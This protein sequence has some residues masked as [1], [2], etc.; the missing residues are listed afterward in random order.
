MPTE[1]N[2]GKAVAERIAVALRPRDGWEA[3]DLGF[4]MVRAWWRPLFT[5]WLAI[6]LPL[7]LA[8]QA[9]LVESPWLAL[10][11]I[12]WLKPLYDRVALFVLSEALFGEAPNLRA[13]VRALPELLRTRLLASLTWLRLSPLRSLQLP[14]VQLERLRGPARSERTR[15][16]I[17]RDSRLAVGLHVVCLHFELVLLIGLLQSLELFAPQAPGVGDLASLLG[18][19]AP[20]GASWTVAA[21]LVALSI[22]EPL[23]V[24]GGFGLYINRRVYLE[25]WD[26]DLMFRR[27]A[28]RRPRNGTAAAAG[29]LALLLVLPSLPAH[30]DEAAP[31]EKAAPFGVECGTAAN[32]AAACI[33]RILDSEEF[34]TTREQT[35]W[36]PRGWSSEPREASEPSV[37]WLGLAEAIARLVRLLA[38]LALL[39]SVTALVYW[40]SRQS[41]AVGYGPATDDPLDP[42]R[43]ED[44]RAADAL[45]ADPVAAARERWRSGD[46]VG[47]LGLLYRAALEHLAGAAGLA[48][49]LGATEEECQRAAEQRAEPA[50]ASDFSSLVRAWQYCAYARS[51]PDEAAFLELC[52]RWQPRLGPVR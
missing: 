8:I 19:T 24:A 40:I 35:Y 10:L 20:E 6:V 28:Q 1:P 21:Y 52:R 5:A 7:A 14:V 33:E 43:R 46:A 17:G 45:P 38:W 41:W 18:E 36:W 15:L 3:I 26:I 16:L 27:L 30:A 44:L 32:D 22:V 2:A 39:V 25:G 37:V 51:V 13:V 23:Y 4:R 42:V 12:W 11:V 49:H 31:S 34:A 29:M 48:L 50:L 47:A 9:S